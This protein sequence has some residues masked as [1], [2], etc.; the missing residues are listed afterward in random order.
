MVNRDNQLVSQWAGLNPEHSPYTLS[1][2]AAFQ[3][4]WP[5]P[6]NQSLCQPVRWGLLSL[7]FSIRGYHR[8]RHYEDCTKKLRG[9]AIRQ[10]KLVPLQHLQ[11]QQKTTL[12]TYCNSSGSSGRFT[13][14]CI[15]LSKICMH[16]NCFRWIFQ[17]HGCSEKFG[18]H[19]SILILIMALTKMIRNTMRSGWWIE[20]MKWH[21]IL[22]IP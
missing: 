2:E 15:L 13:Q 17:H 7:S 3:W 21:T 22:F 10:Q 18:H 9:K 11:Q 20:K 5:K 12:G 8:L 1:K 16:L 4:V 6:A 14:T 19:Q